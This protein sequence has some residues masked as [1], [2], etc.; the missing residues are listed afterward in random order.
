MHEGSQKIIKDNYVILVVDDEPDVVRDTSAVLKMEGYKVIEA[1][2]GKSAVDIVRDQHVD[3][4]VLDYFMPQYTGRRVINEIREFNKEL[5]ILLQTGYAE[6][7]P[8]AEVFETLSIQG[9]HDKTEGT[10]K[11]L[12]WLTAG[13]RTCDQIRQIKNLFEKV[14]V[15]NQTIQDMK[16]NQDKLIEKERLAALGQLVGS[17][18]H[19]MKTPI[20]CIAT[21][22]RWVKDLINELESL[23][24][25]ENVSDEELN[26]VAS[27]MMENIEVVIQ[28][29]SYISE[30]MEVV[31]EQAVQSSVDKVARFTIDQVLK[32][33]KFLM[34]HELM[35]NKCY[36]ITDNQVDPEI[37]LEGSLI[38]LV[39]VLNNLISNA[40]QAYE[41]KEGKI[42]LRITK[43]GDKIEFVVKD[44]ANGIPKEV[45]ERLF[46][47]MVT[48][49]GDKGTGMGVYTSR[50]VIVDKFK[51]EMT[52][53]SEEGEGT[54]FYI[55][56]PIPSV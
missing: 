29:N 47:E 16:E 32:K 13:V 49:K 21:Y 12:L 15:A 43:A 7:K 54:T 36:L 8:P 52:F 25:A 37:Q 56:I 30:L 31:K 53:E 38:N 41:G 42:E 9:Y 11:L 24:G 50:K 27:E 46:N 33:V 55:T 48:S 6:E 51:G 10:E 35:A 39:Q 5:V 14:S 40:I 3:I 1:F 19:N 17:I 28:N 44:K 22:S 4:L 23:I 34:K 26:K 18:S 20:M 45:K 2:G